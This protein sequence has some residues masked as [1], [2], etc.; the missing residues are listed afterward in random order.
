[1]S[2]DASDYMV[3]LAKGEVKLER[4]PNVV[5]MDPPRSGSDPK[6][7]NAVAQLAPEK[8]VYISCNPVTQKVDADILKKKGYQIEKIQAVDCFCHTYHVECII[9]M[10]Y[11]GKEKKK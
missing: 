2:A 1:M 10:Q 3:Q 5:F 11:C 6:F 4:K 8:I 9:M 7:L